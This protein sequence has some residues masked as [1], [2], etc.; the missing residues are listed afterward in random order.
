[1]EWRIGHSGVKERWNG[2]WL[3]MELKEYGKEDGQKWSQREMEWRLGHNEVK[4]RWNGGWM[5]ME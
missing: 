1:M 3:I 4:G 2:G 5:I